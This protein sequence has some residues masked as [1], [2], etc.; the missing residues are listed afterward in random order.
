MRQNKAQDLLW[1]LV[2]FKKITVEKARELMLSNMNE[3]NIAIREARVIRYLVNNNLCDLKTIK[4]ITIIQQID[5]LDALCKQVLDVQNANAVTNLI[6]LNLIDH[7]IAPEHKLNNTGCVHAQFCFAGQKE[8]NQLYTKVKNYKDALKKIYFLKIA[9][10]TQ[11]QEVLAEQTN[12]FNNV[13]NV[14]N[15]FKISLLSLLNVH[16]LEVFASL[17]DDLSK[18]STFFSLD[19]YLNEFFNSYRP[20][21]QLVYQSMLSSLDNPMPSV[22][23]DCQDIPVRKYKVKDLLWMLVDLKKLDYQQACKI[24]FINMFDADPALSDIKL[25]NYLLKHQICTEKQLKAMNIIQQLDCIAYLSAQSI[26][27]KQTNG[28]KSVAAQLWRKFINLNNLDYQ[29]AKENQ[30]VVPDD[31]NDLYREARA[32]KEALKNIYFLVLTR[33]D[34]SSDFLSLYGYLSN[35]IVYNLQSKL[36]GKLSKAEL[37]GFESIRKELRD[38]LNEQWHHQHIARFNEFWDYCNQKLQ[39]KLQH[40]PQEYDF[41]KISR[42]ILAQQDVTAGGPTPSATPLLSPRAS[43]SSFNSS[44]SSSSR[45]TSPRPMLKRS[46]SCLSLPSEQ[47][48]N[49]RRLA[50]SFSYSLTD[51]EGLVRNTRLI[52]GF[53]EVEIQQQASTAATSFSSSGYSLEIDEVELILVPIIRNSSSSSSE[54]KARSSAILPRVKKPKLQE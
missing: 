22:V 32:Y 21:I 33:P 42:N 7:S 50:G 1:L 40:L 30:L 28:N 23:D 10:F 13:L 18:Q 2:D 48:Q 52:G 9:S 39:L 11:Y 31:L 54:L 19:D 12:I 38:L 43:F 53:T 37:V 3:P 14:V 17:R 36:F 4:I 41:I 27:L 24:T 46:T 8:F 35:A 47:N 51:I 44:S 25:I 26:L 20:Q 29:L 49:Y 5:R 34:H 16:E 15:G 6:D 45:S